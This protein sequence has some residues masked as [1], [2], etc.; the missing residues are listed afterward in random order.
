M[1]RTE[2]QHSQ[3]QQQAAP[4][5]R[6]VSLLAAAAVLLQQQYLLTGYVFRYVFLY[7]SCRLGRILQKYMEVYKYI[8]YMPPEIP[9]IPPNLETFG[10]MGE[11]FAKVMHAKLISKKIDAVI[12]EFDAYRLQPSAGGG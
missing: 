3:H 5:A 2:E 11:F 12:D 8:S 7:F 4:P 6:C 9:P 1:R 10:E